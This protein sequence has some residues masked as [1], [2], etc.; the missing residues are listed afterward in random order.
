M[1]RR[2]EI[3]ATLAGAFLAGRWTESAMVRRGREALAPPPRWLPAVAR[4]VLAAYHRPPADR[5]R[6]LAAYIALVLEEREEARPHVR[7]AHVFDTA[8]GRMPWPVPEIASP[9]E[10]AGVLG[11]EI[12]ELLWLADARGLERRAQDERL[13]H[14]RYQWLPRRGGGPPRP[15]ASPKPRL[16]AIQRW[17]LR[18]ILDRIP[19]HDAAHGFVRGRS[20]R[21]HAALHAGAHTVVRIDL[22]DFFASVPA[23]RAYGTF[24]SA[25]YPEAVAHA[26]TALCTTVVPL[27]EWEAVPPADDVHRHS[28]LGRRLATPHLPQGA[29]TSPA[30]ASLA[31]TRLDRRLAALAP[32]LLARYSRYADDL[33]FSGPH[34]LPAGTLR[35]V[36]TGIAREEGFR[37]APGKT[38]VRRPHERQ[39]IC[40]IVVN[41]RP[42]V[43]RR[44]YDALKAILHDAE[45]NGSEAANR[46]GHPEFR[47]HLLGRIAW[48]ESLN[49]QR[50][51]R[52][53]ARL[54][55]L[56][57]R[58]PG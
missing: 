12:G 29:P 31:A 51:G 15:I 7:R 1:Q 5:P 11:L 9:G 46:A 56:S 40:G 58:E 13:R 30:L 43:A 57:A 18:E 35:R 26:L 36:V 42:N 33:A 53:R 44:E 38:T 50:G 28:R 16:K 3:G 49:P 2:R 14:Y 45:L 37:V 22:E 25:G 24:R 23:S 6:E 41:E 27:A 52:L 8:M 54:E 32:T 19:P 48:V 39:L 21:S 4:E 47:A 17:I 10:L 34:D 55:R 20:A